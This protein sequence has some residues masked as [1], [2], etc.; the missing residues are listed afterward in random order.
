TVAAIE[1]IT[2]AL[3]EQKGVL[4]DPPPRALVESLE[5]DGVRVRAYVWAPTQG[6]DWSQLLSDLKLKAKVALQKA[7]VISGEAIAKPA[8]GRGQAGGTTAALHRPILTSEQA[9][10]NLERDAQSAAAKDPPDG[11]NG[12]KP[13]M[14]RAL[15]QPESRV[16][17]EGAN[18]LRNNKAE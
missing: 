11:G 12:V 14:V 9:R 2:R 18:L 4:H 7:G 5:P 16:S 17:E 8:D 3:S 6:V 10:A 1:A 13:P 15:E